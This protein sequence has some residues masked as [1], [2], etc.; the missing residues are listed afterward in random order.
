MRRRAALRVAIRGR[1]LTAWRGL[2][3]VVASLALALSQPAHA[4]DDTSQG[5]HVPYVPTPMNVVEAMLDLAKV[6]PDDFVVDLGSGDGRI[7]I[8]AAKQ[9]GARGFGVEIVPSLV[10]DARREASRQGVADR[11]QF[12]A[13]NMFITDIGQATV[14]TVY[15]FPNILH[16]LRPRLFEQLKPGVR[17]VSHEFDFG[18]WKPDAQ[19]RVKVP[20]KPYGPPVSDVYLWIIPANAAGR[21]QWRTLVEGSEVA[22]ELDLKQ[23]FQALSG[24]VRTG[25]GS[26]RVESVRLRGAEIAL[27]VSSSVN[28]R[29][30]RQE[31]AGVISGDTIRGKARGASGPD[32]PWQATRVARGKIEIEA[33]SSADPPARGDAVNVARLRNVQ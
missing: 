16:Q 10:N 2:S 4:Q 22:W 26:G 19:V 31:L 25:G 18:A 23:T 6:G 20:D 5:Q 3:V 12:R 11:V 8:A 30:V 29:E 33:A 14:L 32:S 17:V 21:W 28:G 15:L 1:S 27:V 13:E 9:R 7:V 24:T